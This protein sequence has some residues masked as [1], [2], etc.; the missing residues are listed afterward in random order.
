MS[1]TKRD[2][3]LKD[4]LRQAKKLA[5][6]YYALT[7]KR[8]G[9]TG[10][11]AENEA[12]E[13]LRLNLVRLEPVSSRLQFYFRG[14]VILCIRDKPPILATFYKCCDTETVSA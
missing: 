5:V 1:Q 4:M 14:N 7:G 9:V 6:H 8:L 10:E 11:V 2:H 12:A 3:A 13:R